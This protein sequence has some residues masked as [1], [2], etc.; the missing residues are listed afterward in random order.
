MN[1]AVGGERRL[2]VRTVA[3]QADRNEDMLN[4]DKSGAKIRRKG[5]R[6]RNGEHSFSHIRTFFALIGFDVTFFVYDIKQQEIKEGK[7]L[8]CRGPDDEREAGVFRSARRDGGKQAYRDEDFDELFGDAGGGAFIDAS[9]GV[10][11]SAENIGE[12]NKR[13][14]Y[15]EHAQRKIGACVAQDMGGNEIRAEKE[16]HGGG[17]AEDER[18]TDAA[19]DRL[20]RARAVV[21]SQLL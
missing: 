9:D 20:N 14:R 7:R 1:C 13:K 18:I 11:I 4:G 15:G 5:D 8:G 10:E 6:K 3:A 16:Q 17:A 2:I 19:L 21:M 12:R